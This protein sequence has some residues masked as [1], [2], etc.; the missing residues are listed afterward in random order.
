MDSRNKIEE[1]IAREIHYFWS[2]WFKFIESNWNE[3]METGVSFRA[4]WRHHANSSY[5]NLTEDEK[6]SFIL[7][8]KTILKEFG[9]TFGDWLSG[10]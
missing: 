2:M 6:I 9:N 7:E 5:D 1:A 3:T 4:F 8:S 10:C